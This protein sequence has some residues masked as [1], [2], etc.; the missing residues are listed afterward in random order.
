VGV[1]LDHGGVG[2]AHEVHDCSFGDAEQQQSGRS[3]VP[4]VVERTDL[5]TARSSQ[6]P[7]SQGARGI[8]ACLNE[9]PGH[10][11]RLYDATANRR[12]GEEQRMRLHD[13]E[14]AILTRLVRQ[15]VAD[16]FPCQ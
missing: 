6:C 2:P 11:T 14:V 13:D 8:P 12:D 7:Q 16:Q 4:G 10:G 5:D 3:C 1:A 9:F 15:L